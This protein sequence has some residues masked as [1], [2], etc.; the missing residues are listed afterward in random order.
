MQRLVSKFWFSLPRST[1][2]GLL[3]SSHTINIY[4]QFRIFRPPDLICL[5]SELTLWNSKDHGR[6][7]PGIP[8]QMLSIYLWTTTIPAQIDLNM[9]CQHSLNW[10]NCR[11]SNDSS[12]YS[13]V[14][15]WFQSRSSPFF[16]N[17]SIKSFGI[18]C[19]FKISRNTNF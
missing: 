8:D 5:Y 14:S 7:E 4:I 1:P 18:S 12:L 9:F 15:R 16:W 11:T 13:L 17:F 6:L 19:R 3:H 2:V 10:L